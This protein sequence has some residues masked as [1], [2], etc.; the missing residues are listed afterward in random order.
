M[1][2]ILSVGIQEGYA[3]P[4]EILN[5]V[6]SGSNRKSL[7]DQLKVFPLRY[8]GEGRM[9]LPPK[10]KRDPKS[11]EVTLVDMIGH[12]PDEADAL[13]IAYY[14]MKKPSTTRKIGA[15]SSSSPGLSLWRD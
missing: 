3:L 6:G 1:F 13:A 11:N 4:S 15:L 12:S 9:T 2:H 10:N 8:D 14:C 7:G 5:K